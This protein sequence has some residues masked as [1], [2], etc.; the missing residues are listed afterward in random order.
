M[1]A[2][3]AALVL[4]GVAFEQW[5]RHAA[6]SRYPPA[7]KL[8]EVDGLLSHL[9]CTG[10]GSPTVVFESG[11][12]TDGAL[13]W[14]LV[15][16]KVA[17]FTRVC[18]YDRAGYVWSDPRGGV[19]DAQT[20][21]RELRALLAKAAELPPYVMVGHSLG[22]PLVRVFDATSPPGAVQGLVLVDASHPGLAKR[23]PE[24]LEPPSE[25]LMTLLE[26]VGLMRLIDEGAPDLPENVRRSVLAFSPQGGATWLAEARALRASFAQASEVGSLGDR[27]LVVLTAVDKPPER[28]ALWRELQ[29]DYAT[30]STNSEHRLISNCD[31][32]IQHQRPELVVTAVRDVVAA[33]R[34]GGRVRHEAAP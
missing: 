25:L 19:R 31:H 1:V 4:A 32:Y 22:G 5:S 26:K 12:D 7:G 23:D 20:I 9:Y 16:P 18:S 24:A 13:G 30:L 3:L 33:V 17:E 11:L 15:Q 14:S 2:S 27:P 10:S 21:A 8:V 34:E 6:A 28:Q 29:D